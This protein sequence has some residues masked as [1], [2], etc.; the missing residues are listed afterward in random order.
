[1]RTRRF[2]YVEYA[3]G[4]REFYDLATDPYELHSLAAS[5]TPVVLAGLHAELAS[6]ENCHTGSACWAAMHVARVP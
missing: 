6:L 2:L 5:L 1:M 4:E 3:D